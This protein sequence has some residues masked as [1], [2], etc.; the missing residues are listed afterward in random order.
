M[1]DG[2]DWLD[3]GGVD[4][5]ASFVDY[6][7]ESVVVIGGVGHFPRR[8]VGL[9]QGVFTLDYVSVTGFPLVLH[10]TGVVVLHAVVEGVFRVSL[11]SENRFK[12]E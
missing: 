8:A 6:R 10:V 1:D 7:V 12:S 9:D 5:V 4:G 3:D 2:Y 11:Q